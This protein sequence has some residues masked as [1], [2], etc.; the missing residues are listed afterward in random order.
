M[1]WVAWQPVIAPLLNEWTLQFIMTG[2]LSEKHLASKGLS[3]YNGMKI[4]MYA[5]QVSNS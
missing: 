4:A 3:S 2:I 1:E 5:R